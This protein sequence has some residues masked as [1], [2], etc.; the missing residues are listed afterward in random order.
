MSTRSMIARRDPDGTLRGRYHHSDGYPS[1]LGK[2][3]WA[4]FHREVADGGFGKDTILMRRVLLEEHPG[5]WSDI[6]GPFDEVGGTGADFRLE[7]GFRGHG[8]PGSA[9]VHYNSD[10]GKWEKNPDFVNNPRCYCHGERGESFDWWTCTC[11][12][13]DRCDNFD[14]EYIY[15]LLDEGMEVWLLKEGE[16]VKYLTYYWTHPEPAWT[17]VNEHIRD[18]RDGKAEA[19]AKEPEAPKKTME[20]YKWVPDEDPDPAYDT[21]KRM[22]TIT[23]PEGMWE[24][25][26]MEAS[27]AVKSAEKT[28][29][30]L[31][32]G[33]GDAGRFAMEELLEYYRRAGVMITQVEDGEYATVEYERF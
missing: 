8:D 9:D 27:Y 2:A 11:P 22:V 21:N 5:G 18:V 6:T 15:V 26:T 17:S 30:I 14:I 13:G 29:A 32:G 16:H 7:P 23:M 4:L 24:S 3:L 31:L 20:D 10:A 33:G 19:P 25:I 12:K 1:G 28:F